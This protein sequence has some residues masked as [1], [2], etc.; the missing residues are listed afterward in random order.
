M[1]PIFCF[2]VLSKPENCCG[3]KESEVLSLLSDVGES[4]VSA[5]LSR[6]PQ[7]LSCELTGF[8]I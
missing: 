5:L 8:P 4:A 7:T 6:V 2:Q 1:N 3:L